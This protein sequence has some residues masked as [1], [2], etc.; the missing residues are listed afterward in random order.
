MR[1]RTASPSLDAPTLQTRWRRLRR[2]T[3]HVLRFNSLRFLGAICG[4]G[5]T[6]TLLRL[7]SFVNVRTTDTTRIHVP[8]CADNESHLSGVGRWTS[9]LDSIMAISLTAQEPPMAFS[10]KGAHV[11]RT[12]YYWGC[13]ITIPSMT[14]LRRAFVIGDD[15]QIQAPGSYNHSSWR[16]GVSS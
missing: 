11:G 16:L 14:S 4:S 2:N 12:E 9:A 3:Q 13:T 7:R 15:G 5:P 8:S 6:I 10:T 1:G